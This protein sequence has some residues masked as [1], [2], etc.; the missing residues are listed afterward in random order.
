[1]K[2]KLNLGCGQYRLPG[3]INLDKID[4]WTWESGLP[5]KDESIDAIT[6][7]H[8]F[9]YI[10]DS[11]WPFVFSELKRVL[12][13]SGILRITEDATDNPLSLWYNGHPEAIALTSYDKIAG[14]LGDGFEVWKTLFNISVDPTLLQNW[15]GGEPKVFFLEARKL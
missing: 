3:F 15:H 1:M 9:M 14:Y 6:E 8:S 12:K 11:D 5:F 10:K 2:L 4:G 7:S 13:P